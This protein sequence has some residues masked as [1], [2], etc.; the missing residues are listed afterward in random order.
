MLRDIL[1]LMT[2]SL[3]DLKNEG[4]TRL[5]VDEENLAALTRAIRPRTGNN[6]PKGDAIPV[7]VQPTPAPATTQLPPPLQIELPPGDPATQ[8]AWL[9]ER[10]L[11]CPTCNAH[12]HPGKQLVFGT[13]PHDAEIFF[14]GEAPGA[15]EET[16][17]EPFVGPAGQLLTRIIEAMGLHRRQVY[18]AN[19]MK[20][21]PEMPTLFGN[22]PPTREEMA[23]CLPFL[24]GTT[25]IEGLLGHDPARTIGKIHGCWQE[26]NGIPLMPTYHPSYLLRNNTN[27][28]KRSVWEDLLLVME[29]IQLPISPRQRDYFL[30]TSPGGNAAH[31]PETAR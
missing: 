14:C 12:K 9:R 25:A 19:I 18:I 15:E 8:L 2:R 5:V 4:V 20:W 10:V 7:A 23:F 1:D 21:R 13:G 6:T 30:Q 26:F 29:R 16:Q 31:P 24:C 3:D 22:R 17:G 11:T 27:R 28:S